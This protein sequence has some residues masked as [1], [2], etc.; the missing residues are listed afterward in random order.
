MGI[1]QHSP[2]QVAIDYTKRHAGHPEVVDFILA[3]NRQ[4]NQLDMRKVIDEKFPGHGI[5]SLLNRM[6]L[7]D[8]AAKPEDIIDI[9]PYIISIHGKFYNMTE[10]PGQPGQYEEKCIDYATPLKYLR[11]HGF[12]GYIN[13]EFEGQRDQQDMGIEKLVDEVEEVRRH[14]EMMRRL[15]V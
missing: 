4:Y 11:E 13:S 5:G 12:D 9:I 15:S 6:C 7:H 1:F 8:M 3:N 10:I 2:S 14:H